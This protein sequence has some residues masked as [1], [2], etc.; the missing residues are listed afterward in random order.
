MTAPTAN[1]AAVPG[2]RLS[3]KEWKKAAKERLEEL[4][5]TYAELE[6]QAAE[7]NFVSTAARKLW[8]FIGGT[9]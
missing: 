2:I 4:N 8:Y 6:Q 1:L 9:L 7:K 5:L 3:R